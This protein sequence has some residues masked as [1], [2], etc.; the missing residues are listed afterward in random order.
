MMPI[1]WESQAGFKSG[2]GGSLG[3]EE[4]GLAA[5]PFASQQ[6]K[7]GSILE[8]FHLL[9]EVS[10]QRRVAG[11]FGDSFILLP[12]PHPGQGKKPREADGRIDFRQLVKDLAKK[13]K[14][15]IEMRRVGVS[16]YADG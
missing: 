14:M 1:L 12:R 16:G 5:F 3:K 6:R 7:S 9:P 13:F 11:A 2:M 15:R 4:A 8:D 10:A